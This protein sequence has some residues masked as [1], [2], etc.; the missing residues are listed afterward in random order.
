MDKGFIHWQIRVYLPVTQMQCV[1][2]YD[3]LLNVVRSGF[4]F[5]VKVNFRQEPGPGFLKLLKLW[6]NLAQYA[7]FTIKILVSSVV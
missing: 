4:Q 3:F 2:G 5:R 6:L 7:M 1:N